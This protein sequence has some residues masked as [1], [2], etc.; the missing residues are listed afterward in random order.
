MCT[1]PLIVNKLYGALGAELKEAAAL[2]VL[3]HLDYLITRDM[4]E[5]EGA[6]DPLSAFYVRSASS[7]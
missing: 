5:A 1:I 4:V 7:S 3:A 2:S 6:A